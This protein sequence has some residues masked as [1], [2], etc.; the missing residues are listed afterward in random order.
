MARGAR[1][2]RNA[3]AVI[4]GLGVFALAGC[5]D[6]RDVE[7]TNRCEY[8]IDVTNS[9]VNA[10][11]GVETLQPGGTATAN[12]SGGPFAVA[13]RASGT[14]DWQVVIPWEEMTEGEDDF[15]R[16]V[17]IEGYKCPSQQG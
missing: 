10:G 3:T 5:D 12:S 6:F 1:R 11:Y 7:V 8:A 14:D 4:A 2:H 17:T 15:T 13:V 9:H 16:T